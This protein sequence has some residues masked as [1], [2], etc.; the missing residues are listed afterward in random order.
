MISA[1]LSGLQSA[2]LLP[3]VLCATFLTTLCFVNTSPAHGHAT[4]PKPHEAV[5]LTVTVPRIVYFSQ[6]FTVV[7]S[8]VGPFGD[9]VKGFSGEV[10]L[11]SDNA[12]SHVKGHLVHGTGSFQ[13]TLKAQKASYVE[14]KT[15]GGEVIEGKS[16]PISPRHP[17]PPKHTR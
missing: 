17:F 8:A 4:E 15:V 2:L 12:V 14:A 6:P 5:K 10:L 13:L 11:T 7:V 9:I 16:H 3:R 1:K